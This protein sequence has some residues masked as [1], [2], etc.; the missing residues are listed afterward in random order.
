MILLDT[1]ALVWWLSRKEKVPKK[2]DK[3]IEAEFKKKEVYY[4]SISV[5]E[6]ALLYFEGR[7]DLRMGVSDWINFLEQ[8]EGFNS[9]P[10]DN[11]I[12]FLSVNLPEKFHKD[13]SDGIIVATAL[14]LGCPIVTSDR[15]IRS[16]K[17][18]KTI[19]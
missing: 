3:I 1:N 10:V 16:Y 5:W 18:V 15:K 7:L 6:I 17:S 13:P 14:V 2:A 4:S 9:V 12:A 19:W 11:K 8:I